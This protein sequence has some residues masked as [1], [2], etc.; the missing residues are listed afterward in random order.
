L[1]IGEMAN[2]SWD[3]VIIGA[4]V[5][6]LAAA[7]E[8]RKSG[9][10]VLILDARDHV[11]GRA[12]TRHEPDLSAPI[13]LGAE[14][15]HGRAPETFELLRE[16]GK[17]ALDTSGAHWTLRDGK[18]V[19]N[20]EDLFGDIQTALER[21]NVLKQPDISFE[22]WLS[23]SAQY[24]LSPEAAAMARAFA[25]GFDAADPARVSAHFIAR[26][27]GS[28]GML[29][30]PQFRPLGG[31]SS[32]L[33][34]LAGALDRENV[35]L[36]LQTV[37]REVRWKRGSVEVDAIFL[38]QP[39]SVRAACAIV[40][41]PLGVLQ[42]PA[43]AAG[44]VRFVPELDTKRKALEGLVSGPVLKLSLRFRRAF[45]EELDGGKY[46]GA[47]FF[48]SAHT[49]FPTFWT[50]LPLRAP[51]L[52][53]WIGGP[54]A[55]RLSMSEMPDIVRQALESLSTIFAGR[56]PSEFELE[57]AYLHNWQ[58]DPFARG[59]YSYIAVGGGD[60][61]STLAA[62]L[63]DTLFFAGEA[64]NTEDEAATVTGAL[65]S[66]ERAARELTERLQAKKVKGPKG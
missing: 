31:Y 22:A 30:S 6:G 18:L 56:P 63:E 49:A 60:A 61:R 59:A 33:A 57:A 66:G 51:L 53:A 39:F 14:F 50:S 13:E 32:V 27:W 65:Q 42:A 12:W 8:L 37:V 26:E 16:V 41:L 29:D 5:S 28:G 34:A 52:I 20:T 25:E 58:T 48:H 7:S 21:S 24:G 55:A 62:P 40:T 1:R 46:E 2:A 36:Q 10:S 11:G 15:I 19:Q 64:T 43:E 47:S 44:A 45:W 3:V 17:A 35:R 54:K 9:L 4:G 38:D 23:R